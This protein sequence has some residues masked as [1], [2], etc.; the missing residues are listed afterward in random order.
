MHH[1]H[2]IEAV[3]RLVTASFV[4]LGEPHAEQLRETILIRGGAYCGRRFEA[5]T[6][7]AIWFLEE[8]QVKLY[9]ADGSVARVIGLASLTPGQRAAA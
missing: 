7:T 3:R 9:R 2:L 1:A 8:N 6:A 5:D 4:E